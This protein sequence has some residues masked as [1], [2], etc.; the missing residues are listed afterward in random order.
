MYYYM[1]TTL[2]PLFVTSRDAAVTAALQRVADRVSAKYDLSI[3]A[4]FHS[5]KMQVAVAAG[6]TDAGLGMGTPSAWRSPCS[7]HARDMAGE[8]S[9]C[10]ARNHRTE[11]CFAIL[12]VAAAMSP[13]IA[14][15][16]Q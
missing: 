4:A 14:S 8:S 15:P 9:P 12:A 6:H 3:A 7:R 2:F 11:P 13:A 16:A 5:P 10:G 1:L